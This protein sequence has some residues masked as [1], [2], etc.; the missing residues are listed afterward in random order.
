MRK[1]IAKTLENKRNYIRFVIVSYVLAFFIPVLLGQFTWVCGVFINAIYILAAMNFH[2]NSFLPIL[3][4]PSIEK[5]AGA[6]A[7]SI[8]FPFLLYLLPFIWVGNISYVYLFRY[9]KSK[10][11]NKS[12]LSLF[13]A[14]IVKTAVI[15]IGT[16]VLYLVGEVY[17]SFILLV[18]AVQLF[19]AFIGGSLALFINKAKI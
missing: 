9:F 12:F 18:G 13:I 11:A 10:W 1:A 14:S 16:I 8:F 15:V 2:K 17:Y 3:F 7:F 4:I 5:V 19:S 6:L